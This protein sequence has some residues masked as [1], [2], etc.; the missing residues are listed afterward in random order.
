MMLGHLQVPLL[1]GTDPASLSQEAY[2]LLRSGRYGGPPF[3]GR[4]FTDDLPR[5]G[6][7]NQRYVVA[8]AVLR[9]L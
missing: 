2:E 7:I 9:A 5:M 3:T 1:T 4:V 8:D 6:A